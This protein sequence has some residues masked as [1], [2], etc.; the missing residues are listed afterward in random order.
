MATWTG[1]KNNQEQFEDIIQ[2]A[3]LAGQRKNIKVPIRTGQKKILFIWQL[4]Q[5]KR[6][7]LK[8]QRKIYIT[9]NQNM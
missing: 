6:I 4:R 1:E 9:S 2:L 3:T 8:W 5:E 7:K